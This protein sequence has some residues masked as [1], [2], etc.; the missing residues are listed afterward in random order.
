MLRAIET[1]YKGYRFRSRLEARY[2]VLFDSLK[3]EWEY[4]PEGYVLED[5]TW[6]LPDFFIRF[7]VGSAK[8]K[9]YPDAG[10]WVEVKPVPPSPAEAAKLVNLCR[11][12]GHH[13]YVLCGPPTRD[14]KAFA[15]DSSRGMTGEAMRLPDSAIVWCCATVRRFEN[16]SANA[17]LARFDRNSEIKTS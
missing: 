3:I 8:R 11:G 17:L 2:A 12:S 5:G 6:Y 9:R 13:G 14:A 10:Y 16:A 15:V 1:R 4:E 7:P